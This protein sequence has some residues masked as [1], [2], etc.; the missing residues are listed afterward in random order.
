VLKALGFP[1]LDSSDSF[2]IQFAWSKSERWIF[3]DSRP[4]LFRRETAAG[5]A[6]KMAQVSVVHEEGPA[7]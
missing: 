4:E 2:A 1:D 5:L 6:E 7:L 3:I